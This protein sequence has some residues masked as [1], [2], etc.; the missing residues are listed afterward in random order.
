LH[1]YNLIEP[2]AAVSELGT[3]ELFAMLPPAFVPAAV[4]SVSYIVAFK[5]ITNE[6]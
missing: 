5:T 2:S 1:F 3:G 4:L 6:R